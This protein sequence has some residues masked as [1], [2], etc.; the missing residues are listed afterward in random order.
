[1]RLPALAALPIFQL[2]CSTFGSDGAGGSGTGGDEDGGQKA[3]D[4]TPADEALLFNALP[5]TPFFVTQGASTTVSLNIVRGR[6]VPDPITVTVEDLPTGV[7]HALLQFG[8][9]EAKAQLV[10]QAAGDAA[11]GPIRAKVRATSGKVTTTTPIEVFVRGAPGT[12]DT[13]FGDRGFVSQVVGDGKEN[14]PA[15]LQMLADDRFVVVGQCDFQRLDSGLPGTSGTCLARFS[16]EGTRDATYGGGAGGVTSLPTHAFPTNAVLAAGGKLVILGGGNSFIPVGKIGIKR[17][18]TD[19][20]LDITFGTGGVCETQINAAGS[21]YV[22]GTARLAIRASDGSLFAAFQND[23]SP[24]T[25]G[26]LRVG[27]NCEAVTSFGS[28]GVTSVGWS[29]GNARVLGLVLRGEKPLLTG[30]AFD[31][32][33]SGWGAAQVDGTSGALDTN[34]GTGGKL[35]YPTAVTTPAQYFA[36]SGQFSGVVILPSGSVIVNYPQSGGFVMASIEPDGKSLTPT[37]G[38]GGLLTVSSERRPTDLVRQSDGKLL[39]NLS[40]SGAEVRRLTSSG[41]LDPAFGNAGVFVDPRLQSW[42]IAQQRDG[43][44][45]ILGAAARDM[46]LLRIWN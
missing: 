5:K 34:F 44:I 36:T 8:I 19:G 40:G 1:M 43:R 24:K 29:T 31:Q 46:A 26:L 16:S 12:L 35:F 2:A 33:A 41:T 45:V 30:R 15:D 10:I 42:R 18:N 13:T 25:V 20:T 23:T 4:G 37:F 7:A 22:A 32:V 27:P 17:L 21:T 9:G 11:Q 14:P 38:V 6:N 39:V 3:V 28:S